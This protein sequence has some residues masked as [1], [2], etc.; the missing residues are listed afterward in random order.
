MPSASIRCGEEDLSSG[1][2]KILRIIVMASG[3]PS[4]FDCDLPMQDSR[5]G[6]GV[7]IQFREPRK[8]VEFE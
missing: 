3:W 7:G 1:H 4:M 5:R 2:V 8:N 6:A